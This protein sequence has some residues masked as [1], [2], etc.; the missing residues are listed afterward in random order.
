[1][2][3]PWG[4]SSGWSSAEFQRV[5]GCSNSDAKTWLSKFDGSLNRALFNFFQEKEVGVGGGELGDAGHEALTELF[6]KYAGEGDEVDLICDNNMDRFFAD[7]EIESNSV[8]TLAI[9]WYLKCEGLGEIARKE[10]LCEFKGNST[11]EDLRHQREVLEKTLKNPNKFGRFYRWL[12]EAAKE[13]SLRRQIDKEVA[14]DMWRIV[15]LGKTSLLDEW[16]E[17]VEDNGTAGITRDLWDQFFEF[18]TD[19]KSDLSNWES[20]GAWPSFIDDF[21]EHLQSRAGKQS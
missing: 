10:F 21:V 12:F 1:M 19:I 5:A 6:D 9:P 16:L 4:A 15:L 8:M 11:I 14:I 13:T 18:I 3:G 17:F 7:I 20:N 2:T